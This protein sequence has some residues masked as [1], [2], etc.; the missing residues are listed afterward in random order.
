MIS[1]LC[2]STSKTDRHGR[3]WKSAQGRTWCPECWSASWVMRAV[4]MPA[5]PVSCT[6][7]EL[8][9]VLR[10]R[11]AE[12]RR[13]ANAIVRALASLERFGADQR[14]EKFDRRAGSQAAD[15]ALKAE[16]PALPTGCSGGVKQAITGRY[17][18]RRIKIAQ[19]KESLPTFRSVPYTFRAERTTLAMDRQVP[20]VTI[21]LSK[22]DRVTFALRQGPHFRRQMQVFR[23]LLSGDAVKGEV[24]LIERPASTGAHRAGPRKTSR[25]MLKI[26]AWVRRQTSAERNGT[27]IVRSQ[28]DCLLSWHVEGS[29]RAERLNFDHLRRWSAEHRRALQRLSDDTKRELRV[30]KRMQRDIAERRERACSKY[31]HRMETAMHQASAFIVGICDRRRIATVVYDDSERAFCQGL[32]WHALKTNLENKLNAIGVSIESAEEESSDE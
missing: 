11:F 12:A 14:L 29:E 19:G 9:P 1:C 25:L 15:S 20:T 13:G 30:P 3:G 7:D 23:A 24:A 21:G 31:R 4:T 18:K 10:E 32:P 26:C 6:W 27:L 8:R 22:T 5:R 28:P 2:G 16:V 17:L